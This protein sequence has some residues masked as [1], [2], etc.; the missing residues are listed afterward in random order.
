M[1]K[2]IEV[3]ATYENG[4]LKLDHPLPLG[5]QQ[6]VRVTIQEKVSRARQSYGLMGWNGDPAVLRRIAEDP[7]FGVEE[8]R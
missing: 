8:S 3:E 5:E 4:I 1:S 2:A 7:E 6:R